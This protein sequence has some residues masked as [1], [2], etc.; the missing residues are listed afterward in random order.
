MTLILPF[1]KTRQRL[2]MN[3]T[4]HHVTTHHRSDKEKE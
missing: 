4:R 3:E 2:K 1:E